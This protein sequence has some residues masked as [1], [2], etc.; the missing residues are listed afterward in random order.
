MIQAFLKTVLADEKTKAWLNVQL[1]TA[2][3]VFRKFKRIFAS[4]RLWLCTGIY[5][6]TDGTGETK[7]HDETGATAKADPPTGA[8]PVGAHLGAKSK[9]GFKAS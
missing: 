5:R 9:E 7:R 8:V 2:F 1:S 3:T 6:G 4:P